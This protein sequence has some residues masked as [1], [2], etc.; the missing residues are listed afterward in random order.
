MAFVERLFKLALGVFLILVALGLTFGSWV[1]IPV[2]LWD[3]L[4]VLVKGSIPVLLVL[5]GLVFVLLSF[6][7]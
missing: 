6:E 2:F 1:G 3:D 5:V 4:V 7:K